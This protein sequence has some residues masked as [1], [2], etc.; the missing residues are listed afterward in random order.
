MMMMMIIKFEGMVWADH[1]V[2]VALIYTTFREAY[3]LKK[4]V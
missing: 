1:V 2:C 3:T 4:F